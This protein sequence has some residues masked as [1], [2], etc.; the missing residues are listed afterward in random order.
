ALQTKSPVMAAGDAIEG[1]EEYY[2]N[3]NINNAAWLPFN[4]YDE[5]GR[6]LPMP[7]RMPA[8]VASAAYVQQ[9]KI[10]Q[11]EMMMVSGQY[12]AQMGE[13]EN[14]KSGIAINQRQRQ[15]DRA[16]YHFLDGQG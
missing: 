7:T 1:Y 3:A 5:E 12:Q 14:A 13:N 6:P 4:A 8:P 15:G 16:T 10:A 9:M 2:K 11:E